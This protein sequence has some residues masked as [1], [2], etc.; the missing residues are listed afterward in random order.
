MLGASAA[1]ILGEI[2]HQTVHRLKVRRV[3]ELPAHP[4]L[5][6]ETR[7]MQMLQMKREG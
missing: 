6:D 5:G 1:A 7:S 4:L 2:R 3:D